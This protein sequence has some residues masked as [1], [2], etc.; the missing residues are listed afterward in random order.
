[1]SFADQDLKP[2][3]DNSQ[4][5]LKELVNESAFSVSYQ[6]SSQSNSSLRSSYYE[7]SYESEEEDSH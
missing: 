4:N 7:P 5:P 2:F 1:M 3:K 6:S